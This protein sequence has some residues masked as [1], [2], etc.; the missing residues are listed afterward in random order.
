[1]NLAGIFRSCNK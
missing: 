1:V